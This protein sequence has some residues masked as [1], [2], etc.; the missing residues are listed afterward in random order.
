MRRLWRPLS[1]RVSIALVLAAM[2]G[3]IAVV[4][5]IARRVDRERAAT[6]QTVRREVESM[7]QFEE[8][9][10]AML[11]ES[12]AVS[13]YYSTQDESY[14][15]LFATSRISVDRALNAVQAALTPEEGQE[16]L[17]IDQLRATHWIVAVAYQRILQS[18]RAGDFASVLL[19]SQ[20]AD[21]MNTPK[22]LLTRLQEGAAD[23]RAEL[24]EVQRREEAARAGAMR[25][26]L[27]MIAVAVFVILAASAGAYR[28]VLRPIANVGKATRA[29][30][31]GD[32][33][34]R[35]P[36]GGPREIAHL[37]ADV[38]RMSEAL[39][40]RSDEVHRYLAKNLEARTAELERS[41]AALE[42][43]EQRFRSLVQNASDMITVVD[44]E[45]ILLYASPSVERVLGYP[46]HDA[47]GAKA[48]AAIHPDDAEH[49]LHMFARALQTP[50]MHPP[51]E[52]RVRHADGSWRHFEATTSNLLNDPAVRGVVHNCRDITDRKRFE[53]RLVDLATYD[54]LTGLLN[55]RSLRE[56]LHREIASA[57]DT[58]GRG[59]VLF[60]DLD[61]F[62]D[63]NDTLGHAAGDDLL[64]ELADLL[65]GELRTGDVIGRLGGDEFAII[66]PEVGPHQAQA[67]GAR[68]L[69]A[70]RHHQFKT[71]GRALSVTASVGLI[72]FPD[73]AR[74]VDELLAGADLAMYHSKR[75]GRNRA[76][77]F[78]PGMASSAGDRL[79]WQRRLRDA[80]DHDRLLLYAQPI[81]DVHGG[82]VDQYE[83]L[84]RLRTDS[85]NVMLPGEFLSGAENMG[86][87]HEVDRWVACRAIEIVA[88]ARDRGA[89][90]RVAANLSAKA[91]SD[92]DLLGLIRD[93]LLHTRIDPAA[94]T[95]EVTESAAITEIDLARQFVDALRALGCKFALDDFGV[96][97]SSLSRLKQL[98]VD[99]LK[100]DGS[101]VRD[102]PRSEIDQKLVQAFVGLARSLGKTTVAEF[103]EDADTLTMLQA[104]GVDYAQGFHLG[105][106][107]PLAE[108][109]GI[110]DPA[111]ET[112]DAA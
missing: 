32:L 25:L 79:S 64:I 22:E 53:S 105:A 12:G 35:A 87:L 21:I 96:G 47:V 61:Q 71:G 107:A 93:Q 99:I 33:T 72:I 34:A 85:G 5:F 76:T 52:F 44:R 23:E 78:E 41:N 86:L 70:I 103:V 92:P 91:F 39:I 24:L 101:F 54:G 57:E 48:I 27:A 38:N 82:F 55:G 15:D 81:V 13:A 37:G 65:R 45:G 66:L 8:A 97:F 83:L 11:N 14:F 50:G 20:D 80:L 89:P 18:L 74:R 58:Q 4:A 6:N 62:K 7:E 59:A 109:L 29:I 94:V 68:L 1:L 36:V 3:A 63:V 56:Q 98:P 106:P 67:A 43:S 75:S 108:T 30:A 28:S 100:I 110:G 73:Q 84:L 46:A 77:I 26:S 31:L 112:R 102:L 42:E 40:R 9:R 49:V 17:R 104:Y 60:L 111:D 2:L 16:S 95:F 19:I 69:G 51:L 88:A 10:I 90:V